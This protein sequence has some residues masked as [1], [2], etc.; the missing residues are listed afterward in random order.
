NTM[1]MLTALGVPADRI[2]R[3]KTELGHVESSKRFNKE[4]ESFFTKGTFPLGFLGMGEDGHTASLFSLE[5][6]RRGHG[7]WSIPITKETPP[8]RISVTR[9]LLHRVERIIILLTGK[10]KLEMLDRLQKKPETIPAGLA[11]LNHPDVSVWYAD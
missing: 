1:P 4:L 3:V 9:E 11:L 10:A 5:D 2:L 6:V 8:H 7:N